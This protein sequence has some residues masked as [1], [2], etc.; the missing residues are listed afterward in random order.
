M[1]ITTI[2][3]CMVVALKFLMTARL[4]INAR[5]VHN[6]EATFVMSTDKLDKGYAFV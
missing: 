2:R 1:K 6:E 3:V 4:A 5:D